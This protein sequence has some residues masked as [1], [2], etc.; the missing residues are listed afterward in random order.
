LNLP[1]SLDFA[2]DQN[3][4][5]DYE[6][7]FIRASE[8]SAATRY[9]SRSGFLFS[10]ILPDVDERMLPGETRRHTPVRVALDKARS[11]R[12]DEDGHRYCR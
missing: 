11:L 2:T 6:A 8:F 12:A 5:R 9:W 7:T 3:A 10:L 1:S 4:P